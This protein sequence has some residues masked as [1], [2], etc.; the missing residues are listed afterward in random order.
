VNKQSLV[1]RRWGVLVSSV[2]FLLLFASA[3]ILMAGCVSYRTVMSQDARHE[4]IPF[5]KDGNTTRDE[6]KQRLGVPSRAFK[7]GRVWIY[8][9]K[10]NE[11]EDTNQDRLVVCGAGP[12]PCTDYQLVLSFADTD[13]VQKHSLIRVR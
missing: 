10:L 4:L 13:V 3:I 8:F 2:P 1:A 11:A 12:Q 6:V 5:V 7:Q 9:L